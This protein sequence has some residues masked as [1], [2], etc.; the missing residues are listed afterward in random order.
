MQVGVWVEDFGEY[1][2]EVLGRGTL[3]SMLA[4]FWGEDFG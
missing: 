1:A 2:G 3:A 4:K